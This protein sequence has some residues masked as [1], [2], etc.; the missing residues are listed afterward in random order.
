MKN[1]ESD[2]GIFCHTIGN[3]D[4]TGYTR[5][6]SMAENTRY[7]AGCRTDKHDNDNRHGCDNG[8]TGYHHIRK[9]Q[10]RNAGSE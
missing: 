2:K 4:N 10:A 6:P 8:A 7:P 1:A 3:C 5:Y 9:H